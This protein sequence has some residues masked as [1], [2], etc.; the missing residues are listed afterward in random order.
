MYLIYKVVHN[1]ASSNIEHFLPSLYGHVPAS[2]PVVV[3]AYMYSRSG[4]NREY[5]RRQRSLCDVIDDECQRS[6]E[7]NPQSYL[8]ALLEKKV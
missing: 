4:K 8:P 5:E 3:A 7:E 6:V 2:V 1:S